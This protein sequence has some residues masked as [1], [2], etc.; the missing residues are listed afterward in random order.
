MQVNAFEEEN[1]EESDEHYFDEDISMSQI[2]KIDTHDDNFIV[3]FN[4]NH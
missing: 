4:L 3:S 1:E 2:P